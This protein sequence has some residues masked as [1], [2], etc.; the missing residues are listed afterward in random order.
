MKVAVVGAGIT[1]LAAG[2]EAA[3]AGAEVVVYEA[4]ERAGGRILTSELAG[5]PVDEGADAFLARVPWAVDLCQELGLAADLVS[6]A[7]RAAF[8]YSRGALRAVP[9]PN[10][11]GVP[12]DFDTLAAS[13]I[14]SADGVDR[15][16][17][18][19]DLAG[20]PLAEDES[21]GGLVRRRLGDE[22]ADR[23]VDPLIGGINASSID[24]LSVRAAVPQLAEAAARGPSLVR[25]MRRL[26][27][28]STADPD[29]PVFYSLPDGVGRLT[30]ELARR[31]EQRLRL[32]SPVVDL[33]E[34]DADQMIVTL[35]AGAA[36]ALVAP[37]SATAAD[38][39]H[40]IDYASVVLVSLAFDT[41]DVD[42]PMAGSGYLV[43]AV[44]GRTITACSWASSKWSHVGT[45]D[46]VVL[47]VSAGR[48]GDDRALA[49]DDDALL[50]AVVDD[51][52]LTMGLDAEP[53]AVRISRWE[54]SLPQFRPGHLELVA[55]IERA[56]SQDA[57]WLRVT[58]AWARGLGIPAC[59]N[60]GRQ[61][62][63]ASVSDGAV[64]R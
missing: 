53:H 23:L 26:A 47:R 52:S 59:I 7:Q 31:L 18:E 32:S 9:Q 27:A 16:R 21:V 34:L 41:A 36:S 28:S 58:G 35:P 15:A 8:V 30:D 51:L 5:Q 14:V 22:V 61:A 4:A 17:Q 1:G 63:R 50:E 60:Q 24:D 6:P 10:V 64:A 56:L 54:R 38:L 44:E 29:A 40:S 19:P 48:F 62:A 49:L 13:G 45:A 12:L 3:K 37:V 25:E 2:Y 43:P 11:L 20:S 39:L 42:H 55:D 57:P 46:T 33:S